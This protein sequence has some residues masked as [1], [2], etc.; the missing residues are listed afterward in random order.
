MWRQALLIAR[1]DLRIFVADRAALMFSLVFPLLFVAI[2]SSFMGGFAGGGDSRMQVYLATYEGPGSISQSIIDGLSASQSGLN[3]TQM[4]ALEAA[5]AL[6][7]G[8]ISGY[9]AFPGDFSERLAAG[10]PTTITVHGDT[11]NPLTGGAL[12]SLA[13]AISAGVTDRWVTITA[14]TRLAAQLGGPEA[15][16]RLGEFLRTIPVSGG[17]NTGSEGGH[18]ASPVAITYQRIGPVVQKTAASWILPGY[19]TMF[20]FFALALTAENLLAER[21][22]YT[23]DRLAA[24]GARPG[25]ILLGKYLGN[26]AR[27]TVQAAVLWGA[28]ILIFKVDAGYTPWM[29]LAVT[30]AIVLCASAFGLLIAAVA[31]SRA[32]AGAMAVFGSLTMAPLG[33]CWWP[34]FMMPAWMQALARIT[35]HAWANAAFGKLLLF[36][37]APASALGDILALLAFG[38]LFGAV[39]RWRFRVET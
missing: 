9:L 37:A 39:A 28:G 8:R 31:K 26:V 30:M 4:G 23:L 3:A 24:N 34:L 12:D 32:A 25:G 6:A 19:V 5:D 33:G 11:E 10:Q 17:S 7:H 1:K 29:T 14:T 38:A 27:G 13:Q 16:A 22:N 35:P 36:A 21:E 18:G 15:L 2:F 20:V